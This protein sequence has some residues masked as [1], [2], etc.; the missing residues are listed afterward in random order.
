MLWLR[1]RLLIKLAGF[2]AL[3]AI[4]P[5]AMAEAGRS[6]LTVSVSTTGENL[7]RTSLPVPVDMLLC[8]AADVSESVTQ[9]E[10]GLQKRGHAAAI[11][12]PH[13]VDTIRKGIH[14][15]IAAAYVEWADQDQQFLAADWHIIDDQASA[16]AFAETIRMSPAPPWIDWSVRNT[17]TSEVVR[18]CLNQFHLAPA[19]SI[20]RV[21]DI[22]SDGTNN[23]GRRIDGVRDLAVS[24]GVVINVLAIEDSLDPFPDGTHTRPDGGLV[25]Y[26]ENNVVG[27]IGSFVHVA[28]GY[29]SFGEMIRRKFLLELAGSASPLAQ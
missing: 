14:G 2:L 16:R 13:V 25:R 12:D 9:E 23:V 3:I 24:Q 22:S 20:R 26:F 8:L 28:S 19:S 1:D 4:A 29:S 6:N 15:R 21:I 11:A 18:Y 27:G 5:A 7:L 17:S 10:Y